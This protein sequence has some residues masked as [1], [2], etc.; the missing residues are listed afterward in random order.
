MRQRIL[1]LAKDV[2]LRSALARCLMPAGYF[3]ELAESDRRA[4]EVLADRRMALTI[5]AA[6]PDAAGAPTFD[7]GEKGGK[8]VIVTAR[9]QDLSPLT[10]STPAADAYV[11][12]P[13]DEQEVL[14]R[15]EA[16]LRAQAEAEPSPEI[17]SFEGFTVDL[18]GRSLR[19]GDGN[20]VPL[21]RAEF[22]LLVTLARHPGRVLSRD[23]L[24]DAALGRR[25]E[26]YDR[27]IDV[28]VGRLR[29]KIEPDP[30]MPRFIVT[31]VGEGYKFAAQLRENNA[32]V[33]STLTAPSGEQ[34]RPHSL[35]TERRRLTVMSCGLVGSTTLASRLD[36]EDLRAVFAEYHRCC[37]GVIA[38]FGGIVA[39]FAGDRVLAYFG[40]PEAHE[41][42]AE[43][44]VRAGL[45]L[46]DA[47]ATL[48]TRLAP[49][50]HVRVGI[51]SGLVVVGDPGPGDTALAPV[52][53][54][55]APDLAAQLQSRAQADTVL[56]AASTR[57]LVRGLFDYREVGPLVLEGLVEPAPAWQVIG[58]SA[59]E[60]RF[61]ALREGNL[62]PL[63]GRDEE[64]D[65]LLRRW[66]Q[67]QS[68]EGRVVLISGEPG[69]GKSRLAR[70]LRDKLGDA[71]ALSFYCSPNH[72]D[73]P[74]YPVVTHLERAAG[75]KRDDSPEERLAKFQAL[76]HP[77]IGDEAVALIA[78]LLSVPGGE[79]YPPPNLTPQR[80]KQGTLAALVAQLVGLASER[81]VLAVFEDAHWMDA[82]SCE[83]L[84]AIADRVRNL[85]VLLVITYRPDFTPAWA[86][87]AHATTLV[88]NRLSNREVTAI[89]DH[90]TGKRLPREVHRQIIEHS[91]GVPL[92][93]EELAKTV[94]ENG[95]LHELDGE[96]RLQGPLSSLAIPSSLQGL[97]IARFDRLGSAKEVAQTGAALGRA[98]TYEAIRAVA[99][100][101][102][103]QQLKEAL[104]T[105]VQS[106][107]L[108]D[109]G[110]PPDVVY[111]FKHA[112]LQDAV[113]E[114][115]LRSRRRELHARIAAVL[116]E[117]FPEVADQQPGLLAHH[118]TEAGSLEQ[119]VIYWGKAGRQSAARS[120]MIEAEAQLRR[121][122]LLIAE[123]PDSR[124]RKRQELDLQVTLASALMESKGH[125]HLEVSE[126]LARARNLIVETEATG[127]ILHFSVLYGLWVAQYLGGA[128][129]AAIEQAKEFLSL[130]QSQTQSGLVLVGHRLV[131]SALVLAG[132]NYPAAL[133]HL[134]RAVELY[135]PEEHRD[136]A[137]R[138]GAD[139]GITAQCARA[140]AL[141]HRGYP[142]QARKAAEEGLGHARQ[143]I[144]RHTL[145]YAL[146]YKGLTAISARWAAETE[147]AANELVAHTREH[148]FALFLGYGL[149]LQAG[150]MV[151]RGEGGAAVERIHEGVAVMRATGVNR[152]E[153][154]VLGNLA[155][156]LALK[157][158]LAEGLQ[159]LAA[160]LAAAEASGTHWADAELHR[161]R[162][163]LLGR[164]PSNDWTEI[165]GCFRTALTV[166]REQGTRGFELRAA[167][168][169]ARLLSA[170]GRRDE[171]CDLLAPVYGWFNE[172]F[173]TPDLKDART[174]LAGLG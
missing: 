54:G 75:F 51:A 44:A 83:L 104:Q 121:G 48:P 105:L 78:A 89:A 102:P 59:A 81:P 170:Q 66:Q 70:A 82:T 85:P 113:H 4:R 61:E 73:S 49:S 36:P 25:A 19:D 112:L 150:A 140:L 65:L 163:E 77:S 24:L 23:Q 149:L 114:T 90:V 120:A 96:Y 15:V 45:A 33:P 29:R 68:G 161:L 5:V 30:K 40:Y 167:V 108:Y 118:H 97:L 46:I 174:L 67:I 100:W 115:L 52:A 50:L 159:T 169:L 21:T 12:L 156:A 80:R 144:H 93:V 76:V 8:L 135:R 148:G 84:D 127:T 41:N 168:S 63:V 141:W 98:F 91:D 94:L 31:V 123:L 165:E 158:A 110:T 72:Q 62:T 55:E 42:D 137:F 27:S 142:D 126:V 119:A 106:Q 13:L 17:L 9:P 147:Q 129:V 22:A 1:I 107:L 111:L 92:F 154:M 139:I 11:S 32:P 128:P 35:S 164:L 133:S 74:L 166:A 124:E 99:D 7:P 116:E 39:P 87:H 53:I 18:A 3:V 38:L 117:R 28:L 64:I 172:G 14:A 157:G 60:S 136:L 131:G 122:L 57:D 143:S 58:T 152:S 56:I 20:E 134:D 71:T 16:V 86:S 6:T 37:A 2:A 34:P 132:R 173:D 69:I 162:G 130:A 10:R 145:A 109:R 103:E 146:I 26:P 160:A 79:R 43:R 171:A 95:L 125:V 155:E 88:L 101:I 151:L 47:A 153:P 138:F